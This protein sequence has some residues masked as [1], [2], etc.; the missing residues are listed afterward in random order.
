MISRH[1]GLALLL[2]GLSGCAFAQS[3]P[4]APVRLV[5]PVAPGGPTDIL[6]RMLGE[7]LS[8]I[9]QQP[10]VI[11]NRGGASGNIGAQ[12][13]AKSKP[14]GYTL[15]IAA[16]NTHG[17]NAAL[18]GQQLGYDPIKD[19]TPIAFVVATTNVLVVNPALKL[20]TLREMLDYAR[21]HPDELT[22]GSGGG[23]TSQFLFMEML[24][25]K[26]N[27]KI[28]DIPYRGSALAITDLIGGQI[29]MMFD[30]M[31]SAAPYIQSGRL[32]ALAVSSA[33]RAKAMPDIPTVEENGVQDFDYV[34]WFGVVGPANLPPD[35]VSKINQDI[36]LV[37]Q[38]PDM[39]EKLQSLGM[40]PVGGSSAFF[41]KYIQ[42]QVATWK[43]VLGEA[44]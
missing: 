7:R 39:R 34:S 31:P 27:V 33:K 12:F 13:V 38:M 8:R 40:E 29:S 4:Q 37:L 9:W 20:G 5:V 19:F 1:F 6:G 14:D 15:Q 42:Q 17:A 35:V 3:F 18:F 24:K 21:A 25:A 30:G 36:N 23:G 28:R 10:V 44:K 11:E 26:A 2:Y 43:Q 41:G 22:S 16:I 32:R